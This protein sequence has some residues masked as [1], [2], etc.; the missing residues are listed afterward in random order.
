MLVEVDAAAGAA[1]VVLVVD[2]VDDDEPEPVV[3]VELLP[4][5]VEDVV[6]E[7]ESLR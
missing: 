4:A 7:R 2:E 1:G 3:D 5:P 6:V